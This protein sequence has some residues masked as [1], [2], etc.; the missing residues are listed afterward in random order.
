MTLYSGHRKKLYNCVSSTQQHSRILAFSHSRI[1]RLGS[2]E[3]ERSDGEPKFAKIRPMRVEMYLCVRRDNP[4]SCSYFT[5][6]HKCIATDSG[7]TT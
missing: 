2:A 7:E 4:C 3:D 6:T 1:K 5:R